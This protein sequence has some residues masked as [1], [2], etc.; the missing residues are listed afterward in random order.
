MRS[1]CW[2]GDDEVMI[3]FDLLTDIV[4]WPKIKGDFQR[5]Q[6][7]LETSVNF[8]LASSNIHTRLHE[9]HVLLFSLLMAEDAALSDEEKE[10][11]GAAAVF[12]DT[13]RRNDRYDVGHGRRAA[14]YYKQFCEQK[15]WIADDRVDFLLSYHDQPD[16]LGLAF[17]KENNFSG[18]KSLYDIF[19]DADGVDRVRL[20]PN[21]LDCDRLRT[22]KSLTLVPLA[23][24]LNQERSINGRAEREMM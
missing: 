7:I 4:L 21:A 6:A 2:S 9:E 8:S 3:S 15:G 5:W 10:V 22:R 19:K 13:R 1:V 17:L 23:K 11:L 12:H 18:L 14:Q 24:Q 20:G 16:E